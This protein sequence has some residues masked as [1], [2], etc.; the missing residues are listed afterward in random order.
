MSDI[1]ATTER[2]VLR[3]FRPDDLPLYS[4]LSADPEV[5]RYLGGPRAAERCAAELT[6][7][8]AQYAAIGYGMLAVERLADGAF[9]GICGLSVER[10]YPDDLQIGWRLFQSYWGKG[11]ATEAA[12]VW[13]DH[14]FEGGASR[15]IS[16]SDVPNIRSH[17]VMQ[18]LGMSY[19]HTATLSD[20]HETFEAHV[21]A[22]AREDWLP[23]GKL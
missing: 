18:R 14:A 21:Y 2:L 1:F 3:D 19:D 6:A 20:D 22:L 11:Y 12:M 23:A 10:W 4:A 9:L 5:M 15:L 16:I 7:I 8:S 17:K 13:R